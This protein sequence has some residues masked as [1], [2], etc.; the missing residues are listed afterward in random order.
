MTLLMFALFSISLIIC[1]MFD[2]SI[3][4]ALIFGY[5][6]FFS[7]GLIKGFSFK[8]MLLFSYEGIKQVKGMLLIFFL[9]GM[10]TAIW[11]A[12]GT[13]PMIIELST[14]FIKPSIFIL[15]VF[16]INC[17]V[18]VLTGTSFGTAA[19]VGVICMTIGNVMGENP[20]FL[21]GAILSGIYFGDRCS[22]MSTSALLVSELTKVDIFEHIRQMIR[23][24]LIPFI[25]TVIFYL[26]LGFFGQAG[27]SP[28]DVTSIFTESFT[29]NGVTLIPAILIFALLLFKIKIKP[30]MLISIGAG[31][32]ICLT[33]Q[34][35]SF[36]KV[37][38]TLW[39]GYEAENAE[40]GLLLN[41]GGIVSMLHVIA[42]VCI[43]SSYFGIFNGTNML[44]HIQKNVDMACK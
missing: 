24:G 27:N 6:L 16:L 4:F 12:A 5:I 18:S 36:S 3:L 14:T 10:M 37:I 40:L 34:Q 32:F 21:G 9:I 19:T 1:V 23:T 17:F 30:T 7:F 28:K 42:V 22:P 33:V 20:L 8:K 29:L 41:G 38:I 31:V 25:M 13:I 44:E 15:E 43:S 39:Q 26:T 35:M 2:F 11:R